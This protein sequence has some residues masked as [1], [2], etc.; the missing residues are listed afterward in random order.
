M[1]LIPKKVIAPATQKNANAAMEK[2]IN[3]DELIND[4]YNLS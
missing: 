4:I 1:S 3:H 2:S